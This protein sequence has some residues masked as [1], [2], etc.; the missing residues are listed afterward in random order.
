MCDRRKCAN[1]DLSREEL[2]RRCDERYRR[3]KE[4]RVRDRDEGGD[5]GRDA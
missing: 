2:E 4:A 3:R 1:H 5:R